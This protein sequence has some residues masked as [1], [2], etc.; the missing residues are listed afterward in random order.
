MEQFENR[1]WGHFEVLSEGT[2]HMVNRVIV[3]SGKRVSYHYH[4]KRSEY[5]IVV[6]GSGNFILDATNRKVSVGDVLYIEPGSYHRIHNTGI[7]DLI[8]IE[9]QLGVCDESDIVRIDDDF[10]R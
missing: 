7:E 10:N 5:W 4:N 2:N 9:T 8:V 3:K 6:Q 1:P